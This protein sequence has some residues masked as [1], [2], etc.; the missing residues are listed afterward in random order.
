MANKFIF[1]FLILLNV[2]CAD[3]KNAEMLYKEAM[4]LIHYDVTRAA[5]MF[6]EACKLKHDRS[7]V[8]LG[9]GKLYAD[10]L[11]RECNKNNG[12]AC[13]GLGVS[14]LDDYEK[15]ERQDIKILAKDLLL[16]SCNLNSKRGCFEL[17]SFFRDNKNLLLKYL[18]KACDLKD[19]YSCGFIG[20]FYDEDAV[21]DIEAH[22]V[23]PLDYKKAREFY[24]KG[25]ELGDGMS[26]TNLALIYLNGR[27]V[28]VNIKKGKDYLIKGC[29][30]GDEE[31]CELYNKSF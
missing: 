26:C 30:L 3:S 23:L 14:Y 9:Y 21:K 12:S 18:H 22:N 27:G 5:D 4:E 15:N 6:K 10:F 24:N 16:K 7:C 20:A 17:S 25:C 11:K 2:A 29:Q 1:L 8:T 13:V 31:A 28:I 19:A